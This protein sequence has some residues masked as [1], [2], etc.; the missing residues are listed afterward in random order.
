MLQEAGHINNTI[1][2]I[3][4]HIQCLHLMYFDVVWVLVSSGAQLQQ[5]MILDSDC[6]P[7]YLSVSFDYE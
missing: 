2:L 6:L 4:W 3:L 5:Q 7:D 1:V